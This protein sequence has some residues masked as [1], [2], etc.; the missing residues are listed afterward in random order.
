[1]AGKRAPRQEAR[2]QGNGIGS[3]LQAM[4]ERFACS[5]EE[6]RLAI[7]AVGEDEERL[8]QHF[9]LVRGLTEFLRRPEV[10]H[11]SPTRR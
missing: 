2:H 4:C 1:M 10:L 8:E 9:D 5:A 6:L 7:E 3:R 11:P